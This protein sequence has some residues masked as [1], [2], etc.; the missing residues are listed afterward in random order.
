MPYID[1]AE[2]GRTKFPA[3]ALL[4]YLAAVLGAGIG[5]YLWGLLFSAL[6]N[7]W[8]APL[9]T[10]VLTGG[11]AGGL[12]RVVGKPG[13]PKIGWCVVFVTLDGCLAGYIYRH[14]YVIPWSNST[15]G[16]KITPDF[17]NAMQYLAND[18]VAVLLSAMGAY[19]A[20]LIATAS[21]PSES[22]PA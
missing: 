10:G 2:T 8:M 11:L 20:Y 6:N 5:A 18:L 15:T 17:A 16:A 7:V 3:S 19:L 12:A 1:D 9:L 22:P 4:P 13:L 21:G 14:I